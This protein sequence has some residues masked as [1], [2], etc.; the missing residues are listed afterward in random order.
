MNAYL[1]Y[2]SILFF[3]V[4]F[5]AIAQVSY[6]KDKKLYYFAITFSFLILFLPAAIRYDIGTDYSNYVD[7]FHKIQQGIIVPKEPLYILFNQLIDYL[8]IDFQW[9]FIVIS[10]LT[11]FLLYKS[12]PIEILAI[13]IFLY[14]VRLYFASYD[15]V[16]QELA[17]AIVIYAMKD[18][19]SLKRYYLWMLLV[20]MI[21]FGTGVVMMLI[22]PF[23]NIKINKIVLILAITL[24]TILVLKTNIVLN[25]LTMIAS[26]FPKYAWYLTSDY[27]Y[28]AKIGSGAGVALRVVIA[29][30]ILYSRDIMLKKYRNLPINAI[31]NMY[32]LYLIF[33]LLA[34]KIHIFGRVQGIFEFFFIFSFSY[35]LI[36]IKG[37]GKYM[38]GMIFLGIYYSF[39]LTSIEKNIKNN[40]N[41]GA[42]INPY[43]TIFY[44]D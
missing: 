6:K 12:L 15:A 2:N 11:Y 5:A 40:E 29:L 8:D 39:F 30:T 18:F 36:T 14:V 19:N 10:F 28:G 22:R 4:F 35:F 34:V 21:H 43:Q 41:K 25:M 32:V 17:I 42:G 13:G 26:F 33:Y 44:K 37:Y 1:V 20:V 9:F 7:Y 31:V 24:L 16:R 23:I 27:V 38:I 3:A